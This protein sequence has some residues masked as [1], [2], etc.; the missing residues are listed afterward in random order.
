M[1]L[2]VTGHMRHRPKPCLWQGPFHN[3]QAS[4][5]LDVQSAH[6]IPLKVNIELV[7]VYSKHVCEHAFWYQETS[8]NFGILASASAL[9]MLC[10]VSK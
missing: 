10:L 8:S 1:V 5:E 2:R 6:Q 9:R 4:L 3:F 7:A